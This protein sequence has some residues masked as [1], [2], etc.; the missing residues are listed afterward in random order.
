MGTNPNR[1]STFRFKQF[2]IENSVSAMK[3]GTDGV[4][5]GAWATADNPLSILDIGAGTGLISIMLAQRFGNA[6]ITGIEIDSQAADEARENVLK[7]PWSDR[8]TIGC[9]DFCRWDTNTKFDLIVSNPPFFTNGIK[10]PDISRASARHAAQ[11][12]PQ[13]IVERGASLLTDNGILAMIIPIEII[14]DLIFSATLNHLNP[15]E[16]TTVTTRVGKSP[17][18]ALISFICHPSQ[19]QKNELIIS[20]QNGFT[21]Q[22]RNL[23]QDFYLQF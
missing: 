14:E 23:T 22:Y 13:S 6:M 4:L 8:I 16:I 7:S 19:V 12:S 20:D 21:S 11:L 9:C 1:C 18:R 3:V 2:E 10:S 5:L 15:R 17:K